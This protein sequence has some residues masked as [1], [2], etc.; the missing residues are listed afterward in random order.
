MI[1]EI[2]T[3][4]LL[5]GARGEPPSDLGAVAECLLRLS[6]LVTDHPNIH[7]LDINP[8]LVYARGKGAVVADARIIL[9]EE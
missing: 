3:I 8:L 1:R 6:A 2:R 9:S 5:Q 4:K 7:E